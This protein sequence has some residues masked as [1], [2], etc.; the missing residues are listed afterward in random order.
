MSGAIELINQVRQRASVKAEPYPTTLNQADAREA[1]RRER[2][3]ELAG[4][5]SRWFDLNPWGIAKEVLNAEHPSGPGQQPFLDKHVIF[6]IPS[7]ERESNQALAS[8]VANE[9]N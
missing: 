8:D 6:P 7:A 3:L 4:E 2:R 1:V 5:Q 9:W